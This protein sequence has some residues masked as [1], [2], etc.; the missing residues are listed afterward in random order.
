MGASDDM[1]QYQFRLFVMRSV[2]AILAGLIIP[3]EEIG[4]PMVTIHNRDAAEELLFASIS[5]IILSVVNNT[6]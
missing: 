1:I 5:Q 2:R 4:G 3:I 6:K